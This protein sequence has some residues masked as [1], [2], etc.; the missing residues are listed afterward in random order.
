[1]APDG[2]KIQHS[3]E[4]RRSQEV[5][6]HILG[7]NRK[8]KT[9]DDIDAAKQYTFSSFAQFKAI[10]VSMGTYS[11]AYPFTFRQLIRV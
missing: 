11:G 3:H 6:D 1:V 8:K 2:R 10:M 4:R 7:N 9:E 5:I